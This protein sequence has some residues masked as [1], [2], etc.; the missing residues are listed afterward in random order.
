M[1]TTLVSA[2]GCRFAESATATSASL[3]MASQSTARK[4]PPIS[5]P[6]LVG[7]K[8]ISVSTL[9]RC[10]C[11]SR[12]STGWRRR[13]GSSAIASAASS[14]RI[15][16]S[17][18]AISA[19][20]RAPSR[21]MAR[22]SSSSSKTS[23]SSSGS[24]CTWPR[25]SVSSS[26]DAFS[27]RSAIWAGFSLRIRANG[28][29]SSALPV[30]P[31]SGSNA[32]HARNACWPRFATGPPSVHAPPAA[33]GA[34]GPRRRAGRAGGPPPGHEPVPAVLL[35]FEVAGLDQVNAL[36]VDQP[37][38]EHVGPQQDLAVAPLERAQVQ[39]GAGELDR[40]TVERDHLLDGHVE[41][42]AADRRHQAGHQGTFRAAQPHDHVGEPADRLAAPVQR[43]AQELRQVQRSRRRGGHG[44][45]F[46]VG[47]G[48]VSSFLPGSP[49][50]AR[51]GPDRGFGE[52]GV[53]RL[54]SAGGMKTTSVL[55][56]SGGR[57]SLAMR[58]AA[59]L[60]GGQPDLDEGPGY[61]LKRR[62][63]GR[64]LI[65]EQLGEQR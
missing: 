6:A 16:V 35:E 1:L 7:L 61:S 4:S 23:A 64:P 36:H 47:V 42:A 12:S 62:L 53:A 32:A 50:H 49:C 57:G 19:S 43:A 28:P 60:L 2:S 40:V 51:P 21:R 17:T 26:L 31:I 41:L 22:S 3:T 56:R 13:C 59:G 58:R 20:V 18:S 33:G 37:V 11:G 45:A 39:P 14:A 27:I 63:L 25:I 34:R 65:N 29:R 30:W 5:P 55:L 9:V 48:P 24:A 8:P 44:L 54:V 10:P 46:L 15:R 52:P 38:A